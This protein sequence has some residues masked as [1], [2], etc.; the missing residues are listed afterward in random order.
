MI[1]VLN[2]Q[3][4]QLVAQGDALLPLDG[5]I[6]G[7]K[8]FDK[9]DFVTNVWNG[10]KVA[11][12][13]YAI[14]QNGEPYGLFYNADLF[15]KAGLKDPW[16][17]YKA[18]TWNEQTFRDAANTIKKKTGIK[19][20][21]AYEAWNYDVLLFMGGG[22]VL[23]PGGKSVTIASAKNAKTLQFFADMIHEGAAPDP[24]VAGGTYLPFFQQQQLAMYLSGAWWSKYMGKVPFKW[25][26]APLPLTWG[27]LG[28]KLEMDSISIS[29]A[30]KNPEAAWAFA[31]TVTDKKGETIWM[32][33]ATPTRKS[34]LARRRSRRTRTT[35]RRARDARTRASPRS[36]RPARPSTPRPA[37]R[38]ARSGSGRRPR[39]RRSPMPR[40]RSGRRCLSGSGP[41]AD[42]LRARAAR[43]RPGLRAA[44]R[45]A[46]S[47]AGG[48]ARRWSP[49]S[50]LAP[51]LI[52]MCAFY[53]G[54][55]IASFAY[56]LT[57]TR[58]SRK[59]VWIGLSNYREI[60][61]D[62]AVPPGAQGHGRLHLFSLGV[63]VGI[64]LACR[65]L[66]NG[67]RR[68][69]GMVRT[70]SSC[71]RSSRSSPMAVLWGW[72]FNRDFGLAN[73][74]LARLGLPRAGFFQVRQPGAPA[75]DLV[76]IWGIG[77]AFVV[78]LPAC[79]RSRTTCTRR[80]PSTAPGR[81]G[82]SGT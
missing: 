17:Q 64:A 80:S 12:K 18:G 16:T 37:R 15:A 31:K 23:A 82:A 51:W 74:V 34:V 73:Y 25:G 70:S 3:P 52:G 60:A 10:G 22:T 11:G 62:G 40:G 61:S 29:K 38:S 28:S 9:S 43:A 35:R 30:T 63:Y 39:R 69:I 44:A 66:C 8:T 68:G 32:Q 26:H 20:G 55:M 27:H 67:R 79:S 1:R 42:H 19:Y 65:L 81:C 54:P 75:L 59:P 7:D 48:G 5:L 21:A 71:R 41:G 76:S 4:T 6:A 33:S 46:G 24:N 56:S 72:L 77:S 14:P 49:T 47:R 58:S 13:Q 50:F 53:L 45:G 36:R 2:Y 78:F 57:T